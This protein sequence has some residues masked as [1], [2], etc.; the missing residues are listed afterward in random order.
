MPRRVTATPKP[1]GLGTSTPLTLEW[2]VCVKRWDGSQNART[3]SEGGE[4]KEA[5][6]YVSLPGV[7]Q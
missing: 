4:Q 6:V 1:F 5:S 3:E 7:W 2:V